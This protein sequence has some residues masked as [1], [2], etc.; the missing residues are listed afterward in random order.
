M[1]LQAIN[2]LKCQLMRD[3]SWL[4]EDKM[5]KGQCDLCAPSHTTTLAFFH[6]LDLV[7]SHMA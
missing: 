1:L 7:K 4:S 3:H 2:E 5:V 6:F